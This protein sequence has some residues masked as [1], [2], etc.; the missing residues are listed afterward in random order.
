MDLSLVADADCVEND[1]EIQNG[2]LEVEVRNSGPNRCCR[3]TA[4]TNFFKF[5]WEVLGRCC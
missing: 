4:Q 2:M 5:W 1:L 3:D